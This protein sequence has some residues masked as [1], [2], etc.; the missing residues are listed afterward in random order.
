[1]RRKTTATRIVRG[2]TEIEIGTG[3]T[4]I[5]MAGGIETA[6]GGTTGEIETGI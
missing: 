5:E 6:I 3:G 1:M 2:E 4:G